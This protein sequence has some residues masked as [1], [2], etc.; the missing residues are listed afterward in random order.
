MP[1]Y[2]THRELSLMASGMT[3]GFAAAPVQFTHGKGCLLFDA[4][5]NE[6]IDFCSGTFTNAYGHAHPKATAFMRKRLGEMW[7]I[8]DYSSPYRLPLLEKL[9]E[10]TPAH[11]DRFQFYTGGS[12]TVEAGLRAL[13][14]YLPDGKN[15]VAA[16]SGAYHGKTLG[17]RQLF[18]WRFP[19]EEHAATV[20]L[21]FPDYFGLAADYKSEYESVCIEQIERIFTR[22]HELGAV[23]FEPIQ[24][25]G[26]NLYASQ[27]F[28]DRF[29]ELCKKYQILMF[30]DE[31]C[32]GFGRVGYDFSFQKY[33]LQP[34]LIAF[35]KGIGGGFPTMCLAGRS[36]IINAGPFG[37]LGGASTTFGGNPLSIAAMHV[38]LEIYQQEQLAE[39]AKLLAPVIEAYV[40]KLKEHHESIF[41]VRSAGLMATLCLKTGEKVQSKE[42]SLLLHQTCLKL[43]VKVMTFDHLFRIAPPLNISKDLLVVGLERMEEAFVKTRNIA[44]CQLNKR[45]K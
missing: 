5:G 25:A 9:N 43:G 42:F 19:G 29:I 13:Y 7:N 4:A 30:A 11:I 31:I 16:F 23:I 24:G 22:H 45:L 3:P 36:D 10:M 2:A 34:D 26:G 18:Q 35:A 12:E 8:H 32:V 39:K 40:S 1:E 6:Y 28:W 33:G 20:Q 44:K 14:S 37:D 27:W 15:R 41:D 17:S 21:P 38:S